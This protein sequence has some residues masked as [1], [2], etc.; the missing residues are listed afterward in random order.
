MHKYSILV[1]NH[2]FFPFSL[3]ETTY[4]ISSFT[5]MTK[6]EGVYM[7][8]KM[9]ST[10]NE[11]SVH[12]KTNSVDINF[13]CGWNETNSFWGWFEISGPLGKSQSFSFKHVPMFLFIW[14]HFGQ[15]LHDFLSSEMKFCFCQNDHNEITP[16]MSFT[17]SCIK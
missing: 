5:L 6:L 8:D 13:H 14:F 15:C 4:V 7:R 9:K 10:R 2:F 12:H 3:S 16:T 1:W 17:S 11:I